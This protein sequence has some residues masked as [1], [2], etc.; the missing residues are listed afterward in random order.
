MLAVTSVSRR[1]L[2]A[3]ENAWLVIT[4]ISIMN[5]RDTTQSQETERRHAQEVEAKDLLVVQNLELRM[6]IIRRWGPQ[7]NEWKQA[8]TMVGKRR[9]Q[10][11]LDAL[12][13]LIV[14]RMFEL[15]KM[16]MSQ[17]GALLT[18]LLSI[19]LTMKSGYKLRKHIGNALKARSKAVR[20]ALQNYNV[21]AQALA[22]P[23]PALSW[24]DVVEYAFLADFDLLSDTRSDV[25]LRVWAK[26]AS[27]ILM[28]QHFKMER[29]REEIVRLN[30]EVPRLTTYIRDE[31]AFLLQ[32]E[33]LLSQ[34][35]P[36]LSRQLRLRRLKLIR[37]ND[38]HIRRLNKLASLPGFSGTIEPGI[39]IEAA[40]HHRA[41]NDALNR[42]AAQEHAG[43][44]EEEEDDEE[45]LA[46][47]EVADMFCLV[48]E[49]LH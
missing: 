38:L 48:V 2:A 45:E 29:A 33:E 47:A 24:D 40:A 12:E 17:T 7:D 22:P 6:G 18:T 21:A 43:G 49:G 23:R 46:G 28:D 26:P 19:E 36:P 16:N 37:S 41:E 35:D 10:R 32:Q 39:S 3:A 30:V 4:P 34:S 1:R 20:T 13:G 14:A 5:T 15:T 9:Y 11:C 27:R 44:D 31:E 8:S 25:R 42:N